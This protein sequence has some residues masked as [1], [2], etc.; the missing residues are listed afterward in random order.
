MEIEFEGATYRRNP[1]SKTRSGRVYYW[2]S[3]DS[4][5]RAI[6]RSVHGPIPDGYHV[7]HE[8][9][10][11]FNNDPGNLVALT[12]LDHAARHPEVAGAPLEHLERIRPLATEWHRSPEGRAW[13]REHAR[14]TW[15]DREPVVLET[16]CTWCGGEVETLVPGGRG[17][18]FCSRRC[19]R[20]K[21]DSE[22]RYD[23]RVTCP[24]CGA[25]FWRNKYRETPVTCGRSCGA[26]LRSE[27]ARA[28]LGSPGGG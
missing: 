13:H 25:E 17:D 28:R 22:H 14:R 20:A 18:R 3:D 8:D 16:G 19:H 26:R 21:A 6:Y 15:D 12:P 24:I 7:H 11:P 1:D 2:G 9:H 27:R 23:V 5:H 4:L 10:D